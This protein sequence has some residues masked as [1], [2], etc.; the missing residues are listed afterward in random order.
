MSLASHLAGLPAGMG[1]TRPTAMLSPPADLALPYPTCMPDNAL[2]HS[3]TLGAFAPWPFGTALPARFWL[4][5]E[6]LYAPAPHLLV[7]TPAYSNDA[8]GDRK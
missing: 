8:S 3:M 2:S 7:R 6:G 5:Y 4:G 1:L